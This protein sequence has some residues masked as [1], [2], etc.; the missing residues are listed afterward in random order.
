MK[1]PYG[2]V[3]TIPYQEVDGSW[4]RTLIST[5]DSIDH[6]RIK[7]GIRKWIKQ[8][9]GRS[10]GPYELRKVCRKVIKHKQPM[11]Y[12]AQKLKVPEE[13]APTDGT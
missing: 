12:I 3:L 13:Y 5:N 6:R 8:N 9:L 4:N 11:M 10:I 2:F 1:Y 7:R